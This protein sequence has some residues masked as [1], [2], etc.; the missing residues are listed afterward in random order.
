M[1]K[2]QDC[3]YRQRIESEN[4]SSYFM[5]NYKY[6]MDKKAGEKKRQEIPPN[7]ISLLLARELSKRDYVYHHIGLETI[8]LHKDDY[9]LFG[10]RILSEKNR[11]RV[12]S[13]KL[14]CKKKP[15]ASPCRPMARFVFP[16]SAPS[17]PLSLTHRRVWWTFLFHVDK[18][19]AICS[20]APSTGW[21]L[22]RLCGSGI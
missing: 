21:G 13:F 11:Q 16:L 10:G 7:D 3:L 8:L 22:S 4:K 19:S 18:Y 5:S 15:A 14:R 2:G 12:D 9:E 17:S 1:E 6:V 20:P